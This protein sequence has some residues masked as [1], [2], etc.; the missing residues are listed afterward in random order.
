[1]FG[2]RWR[3]G[4]AQ[5]D[6]IEHQLRVGI[7][8]CQRIEQLE[9]VPGQDVDRQ[10]VRSAG[11]QDACKT[12]VRGGRGGLVQQDDAR[13]DRTRCACPLGD[14]FTDRGRGGI[15]RFDQTESARVAGMDFQRIARVEAIQSP[16]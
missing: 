11:L 6:M 3:K 15:E 9:F 8:A 7:G 12:G 2:R 16:G 14:F 10:I 4:L 5:A 1:M 13:A